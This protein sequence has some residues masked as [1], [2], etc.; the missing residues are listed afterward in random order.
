MPNVRGE[1]VW[2]RKRVVEKGEMEVLGTAINEHV[3]SFFVCKHSCIAL[4]NMIEKNSKE[5]IR[6]LI[7]LGGAARS[8]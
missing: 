6:L 1:R 7:S 4:S 2:W 8:E 3:S 5:D